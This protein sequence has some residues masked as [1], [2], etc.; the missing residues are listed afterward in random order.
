[1]EYH[2]RQY[3]YLFVHS[4]VPMNPGDFKE[5]DIV[6]ATG[7]FIAYP[8][9]TKKHYKAVFTLRSLTLV[10][11]SVREVCR[12]RSLSNGRSAGSY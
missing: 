5:G 7:A 9:A 4:N 2:T 6:E 10:D 12:A 11:S 3:F 8:T 1:M